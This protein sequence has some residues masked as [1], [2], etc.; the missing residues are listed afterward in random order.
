MPSP[1]FLLPAACLLFAGACMASNQPNIVFVHV[2]DLG[3]QDTSV[4]MHVEPTPFNRRYHTPAMQRLA[5]TGTVL[6]DNYA[7]A[8]V[9]T[10]SRTSLLTGQSPARTGITYWTL[11]RDRD[12]S[13]NHPV[14]QAPVWNMNGLDA[15]DVTLPRLLRRA[16]YRTIHAGKAHFGAHGTPGADPMALG[17]EVNIAGHASGAPGSYLGRHRF[18]NSAWGTGSSWLMK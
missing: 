2:D 11:H 14:L 17:F 18:M 12:T 5:D 4:P 3:W 15:E 6:T 10:P 1:P 16:G 9:C 7:A 8:P 13:R